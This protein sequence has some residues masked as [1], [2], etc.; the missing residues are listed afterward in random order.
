MPT[1][2]YFI[3]FILLMREDGSWPNNMIITIIEIYDI[4]KKIEREVKKLRR[5]WLKNSTGFLDPSYKLI[6]S[7]EPSALKNN[8]GRFDCPTFDPSV[9][10][11]SIFLSK[12]LTS[13]TNKQAKLKRN[14]GCHF[15]FEIPKYLL[16]SFFYLVRRSSTD[17]IIL[18][19]MDPKV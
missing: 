9:S 16:L 2:W 13:R 4:V 15:T 18:V 19:Y 11:S 10:F 7:I 5:S 1:K 8:K 12:P 14:L 3:H 6:H 17:L